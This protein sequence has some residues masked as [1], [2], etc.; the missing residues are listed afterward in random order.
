MIK[1]LQEVNDIPTFANRK[2]EVTCLQNYW[3]GSSVG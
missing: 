2:E 1:S 3:F